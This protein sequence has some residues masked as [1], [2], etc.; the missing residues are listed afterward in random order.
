MAL[1]RQYVIERLRCYAAVKRATNIIRCQR[2]IEMPTRRYED[3]ARLLM[4]DTR[5]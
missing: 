2:V 1:V 5:G 3:M 4:M